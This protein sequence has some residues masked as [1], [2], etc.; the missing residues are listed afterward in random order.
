MRKKLFLLL[1]F[2]SLLSAFQWDYSHDFVLKKDEVGVIEVTKREDQ[3]KRLLHLRWTLFE[4]KRLVVLVKYDD[5]P[6]QYVLQKEYKRNSIKIT[7]RDDYSDSFKRCF[8]IIKFDD[9]STAKKTARLEV[10]IT[11]P[12]KIVE[13]KFIDPKKSKG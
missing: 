4:N 9:F 12:K 1:L 11:D 3:S 5:F 10:S 8:L 13:I 7:L 6:T 2:S